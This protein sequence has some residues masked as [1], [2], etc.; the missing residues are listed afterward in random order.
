MKIFS[1]RVEVPATTKPAAP[2]VAR[3]TLPNAVI[4]SI[5]AR[6]SEAT[7][8]EQTG[9][10]ITNQGLNVFPNS[11]KGL[12]AGED[13]YSPFLGAE[14]IAIQETLSGPPYEVEVVFFNLT[15]SAVFADVLISTD[16]KEKTRQVEAVHPL[17][18]ETNKLV[19]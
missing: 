3:V 16:G 6:C 8:P 10:K 2:F 14:E 19:D 4:K 5:I 11:G 12:A 1:L 15:A 18:L 7:N 17:D 13:G 9:F